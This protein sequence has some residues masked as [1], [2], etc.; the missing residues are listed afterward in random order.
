M[1]ISLQLAYKTTLI[2]EEIV[3]D[4]LVRVNKFVFSV[5]F[6]VVNMDENTHHPRMTIL[7]N[8]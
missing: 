8:G 7:S 1:S 6:I 3:E 5:D 2:P 4:V